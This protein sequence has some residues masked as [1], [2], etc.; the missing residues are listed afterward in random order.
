MA[1][2]P[3]YVSI[4]FSE[5][6]TDKNLNFIRQY[7]KKGLCEEINHFDEKNIVDIVGRKLTKNKLEISKA[8]CVADGTRKRGVP[9]FEL[10]NSNLE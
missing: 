10:L 5:I 7:R 6:K 1:S 2:V 4:V 3:D 8:L 9:N